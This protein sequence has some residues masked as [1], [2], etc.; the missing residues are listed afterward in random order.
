MTNDNDHDLLIAL[1][2]R[3]DMVIKYMSENGSQMMQIMGRISA[4]ETKDSRDSE[5][6]QAISAN[7]QSSLHNG[8]RITVLESEIRGLKD[9]VKT[10]R[11]RGNTWDTINSI[12]IGI[13]TFVA[14]IF[15]R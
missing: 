1:N 9:E 12:G 4:L 10:L 15:G 11:S 14:Y 8:E 3:M 2:T 5:K 6:V 13:G 7:V